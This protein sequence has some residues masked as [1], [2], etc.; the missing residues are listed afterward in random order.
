MTIPRPQLLHCR[1]GRRSP[2]RSSAF[3]VLGVLPSRSA[4][5]LAVRPDGLVR[6]IFRIRLAES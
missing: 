1:P 4:T 2:E 3:G 6:R 5:S